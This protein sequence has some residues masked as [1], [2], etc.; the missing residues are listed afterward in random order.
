MPE[1]LAPKLKKIEVK[2]D[3]LVLDPNNPRFI[4]RHEDKIAEE[5]FLGHDTSGKTVS[6]MSKER[7]KI[8]E[9]ANS[10][11][12]NHWQPVD[13]IFVRKLEGQKDRFVVLEGNRRVTAIRE[14]M[15]DPKADST[16]KESLKSIEVMEVIEGGSS[17]ELQRKITYLLGVRHHGSL[18]KWT[19]FAQAHNIM[20]R[21]LEIS[22]QSQETF[23]WDSAHARKVADTFSI[24]VEE[25]EKR[26]KVYRVMNQVGNSPDVKN[27]PGGMKDR[28]YSVC[29]E[30]V[31]SPRKKLR[32]YIVQ[33]PKTFRLTEES[34]TRMNNL[35]HFSVED[36]KDAAIV[37]PQ[38]W[39]YLEKILAD[40]DQTKRLAM[41][42]KVEQEKRIPS[43]AWAVRAK[44]LAHYTWERWLLEVNSILK[45]VT[46]NELTN[47][48]DAVPTV[49]QLL[50]LI[51]DLDRRDIY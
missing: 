23:D 35:C 30:P 41:L 39:R 10:I 12:Q 11:K 34:V 36:R 33:D 50:N 3:H 5:D 19:A 47:T 40:E 27:S 28:Y 16:L 17:E 49:K 1:K 29:A 43:E 26:L 20:E 37:N 15:K 18:K 38:E 22:G 7:Y 51:A 2:Y 44:E 13:S 4:T 6:K 46:L 21:Y 48:K 25:V 45:T 24:P 42:A 32:E 31:L 8:A 14:I 9:L